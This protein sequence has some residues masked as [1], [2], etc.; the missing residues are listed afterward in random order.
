[1][2][3][4]W[5]KKLRGLTGLTAIGGLLG[6]VLGSLWLGASTLL[7]GG[8]VS[9]GLLLSGAAIYGGFAALATGGV[10]VLLATVGSGRTLSELSAARAGVCGALL[11]AVAPVLGL[12][13]FASFP[14]AILASAALRFGVLGGALGA[15]LV[16]MRARI[17][18]L[19]R[20]EAR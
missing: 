11:G 2:I 1:M 19:S 15:G 14:I 20:V 6:G 10:G 18:S 12:S 13:L 4:R 16:T 5:W 3:R 7:A 17:A 9:P 8:S